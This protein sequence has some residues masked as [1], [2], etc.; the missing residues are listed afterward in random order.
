MDT[1]E[2]EKKYQQ[3]QREL[4]QIG[5][6][7]NG[8][9]MTLYRKCGKPECSCNE[10]QSLG[11]GPYYIWTRKENGKT[12]TRSLSKERFQKCQQ[13]IQ[14]YKRMESI[15]EEMKRISVQIFEQDE[16]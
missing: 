13:C 2:L 4:A 7:C 10:D 6:I 9:I 1:K 15:I 8:S 11:H 16:L 3:L 14:N 12:T 5:Y